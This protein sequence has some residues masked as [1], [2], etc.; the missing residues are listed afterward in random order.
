M[1]SIFLSTRPSS[2]RAVLLVLFGACACGQIDEGG[3]PVG[4]S[5]QL[6]GLVTGCELSDSLEKE[7]IGW[8]ASTARLSGWKLDVDR[9]S[10]TP[11]P[12]MKPFSAGTIPADWLED[13]PASVRQNWNGL[14]EEE[15]DTE[16]AGL[17]EGVTRPTCGDSEGA[18]LSSHLYAI[19]V[20]HARTE[21]PVP[22]CDTSEEDC[23][24]TVEGFQDWG[25]AVV[26]DWTSVSGGRP[27][28]VGEEGEPGSWDGIA[29]WAK[30]TAVSE[31]DHELT[32]ETGRSMFVAVTDKYTIESPPWAF[33]K[34]DG[35]T[36]C[37][38]ST[39]DAEK[40]DRFGVGVGLESE[41]NFYKVPFS[42]MSQRGYGVPSPG[43]DRGGIIAISMYL[44]DGPWDMWIADV[45]FYRENPEP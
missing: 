13:M 40:C 44:S 22:G 21:V 14:T 19:H 33:E 38:N 1:E 7:P 31:L 29:F 41:W 10:Y 37:S 12:R 34:E 35:T 36:F 11:A 18:S 25:G 26:H 6:E 17:I 43:I 39:V 27:V 15:R 42:L 4:D 30:R 20:E 9:S 2:R 24:L 32:R 16:Q 8:N 3:R 23:L 45:S 5:N 28:D